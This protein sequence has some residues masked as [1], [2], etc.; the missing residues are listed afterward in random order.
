ML[1]YP[2]QPQPY[3]HQTRKRRSVRSVE[4][5]AERSPKRTRLTEKNLKAF[6]KIGGRQRKSAGKKSTGQSSSTTTTITTDKDFGLQLQR[7]NVVYSRIDA[8]APDDID[9]VRKL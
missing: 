1:E 2:C 8:R 7:N 4:T 3:N 6:E 5:G 9:E